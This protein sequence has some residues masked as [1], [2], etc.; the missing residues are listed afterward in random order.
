MRLQLYTGDG[1][2]GGSTLSTVGEQRGRG[3]EWIG[4]GMDTHRWIH[5]TATNGMSHTYQRRKHT[6][7]YTD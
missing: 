5:N 2:R 3:G 7:L 4:V 1:E 6:Q